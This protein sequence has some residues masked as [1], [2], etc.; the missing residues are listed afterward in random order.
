MKTKSIR[1]GKIRTITTTVIVRFAF[2]WMQSLQFCSA[3]SNERIENN[4]ESMGA[5]HS[6][7]TIGARNP[8]M[9]CQK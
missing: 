8:N 4:I 2:E 9:V 1:S 7:E 3:Q 5:V 6:I